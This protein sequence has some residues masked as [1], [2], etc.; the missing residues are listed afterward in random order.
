VQLTVLGRYGA[1]PAAGGACSGYL[2]QDGDTN[3]LL[4]CGSGIVSRL[5]NFCSWTN[6][7]A[8]VITHFHADHYL[9]LYPLRYALQ[10]S[11]FN[12]RKDK[13]LVLVP[14]GGDIELTRIFSNEESKKSF[15]DPFLFREIGSEEERIGSLQLNFLQVNHPVPTYAVKVRNNNCQLV[16]TSDTSFHGQLI[17][18]SKG[19]SLLLAEST[20]RNED[21]DRSELTGH[22]TAGQAGELASIAGVKKL[23]LTHFW[24]EFSLEQYAK[25]AGETYGKEVIIAEE[26]ESYWID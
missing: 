20:L 12:K 6:L 7:S 19:S 15:A 11:K 3:L 8:I 14:P 5:Q 16:Y 26:G 21:E 9:D 13:L 18:F 23:M 22:L 2:L 24:P 10:L 17:D 1:Y 25:E 4:D